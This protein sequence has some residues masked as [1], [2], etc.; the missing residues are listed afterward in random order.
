[1][2]SR[3]RYLGYPY[4]LLCQ[5]KRFSPEQ[6]PLY[7]EPCIRVFGSA[8]REARG[9]IAGQMVLYHRVDRC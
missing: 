5:T 6:Y 9:C 7:L 2:E 8:R 1:M 4:M 3:R